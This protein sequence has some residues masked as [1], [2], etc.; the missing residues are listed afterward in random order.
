MV[1]LVFEIKYILN[2]LSLEVKKGDCI[3]FGAVRKWKEYIHDIIISRYI[4][5]NMCLHGL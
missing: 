1:L 3:Y 4:N 2:G 5:V